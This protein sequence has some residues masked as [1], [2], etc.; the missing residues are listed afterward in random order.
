MEERTYHC[1][2]VGVQ[3]HRCGHGGRDELNFIGELEVAKGD[4]YTHRALR[5]D[6]AASAAAWSFLT[7]YGDRLDDAESWI[8]YEI[9]VQVDDD[10]VYR[11]DFR[12]GLE[13]TRRPHLVG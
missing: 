8:D 13:R 12:Y 3:A 2:I 1:R 6:S 9:R 11:V 10:R 4:D 7:T 5:A